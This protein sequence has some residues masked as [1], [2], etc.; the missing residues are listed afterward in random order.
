MSPSRSY[1]GPALSVTYQH[2]SELPVPEDEADCVIVALEDDVVQTNSSAA[3]W[4]FNTHTA[5]I[6]AV[7]DLRNIGPTLAE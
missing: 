7:E 6:I 2:I 1:D 5:G 4:E 3:N